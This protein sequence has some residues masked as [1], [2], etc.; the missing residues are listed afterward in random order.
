MTSLPQR[1]PD[2]FIAPPSLLE[3]VTAPE[4]TLP[5]GFM[6]PDTAPWTD[7]Q[8]SGGIGD[9]AAAGA[10]A[11]AFPQYMEDG[12]WGSGSSGPE[13]D[14]EVARRLVQSG[15]R[16]SDEVDT[17]YLLQEMTP[18]EKELYFRPLRV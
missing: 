7:W 8:P 5:L 10:A 14:Y 16:G 4:P 9:I 12:C 15:G 17:E 6:D 18:E 3:P 2:P 1:R 11:A 13:P